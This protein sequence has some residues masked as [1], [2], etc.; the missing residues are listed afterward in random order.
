MDLKTV[1]SILG[2][3]ESYQAPEKL[4]K[5]LFDKE[6][7]EAMFKKFLEH[8]HKMDFD[9]F[10]EYFQ[11]EHAEKK[12]KKQDFTP[13]SISHLL[14]RLTVGENGCGRTLDVAAGTGGITI[15]KWHHDRLQ[16][17][18]WEYKPSNYFYQCEELSDRAIPFLLF[19]LMIRGM[20]ATVVHGDSLL[21]EAKQI[22]FIQ[23]ENDDF[24]AF[25]SLNVMPHSEVAAKE[26]GV[27]EWLEDAIE[28]TESEGM[29][30]HLKGV[31]NNGK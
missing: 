4:M 5:T 17:S 11:E 6:K 3:T 16:Q 22:Y 30:E 24:M 25:S 26:F 9:W 31:V 19:N 27:K 15:A 14:A 8:E 21:R 10:H 23:N 12:S 28:H 7:R 1:N 29:P 18:P 2:I 13:Q 20:N